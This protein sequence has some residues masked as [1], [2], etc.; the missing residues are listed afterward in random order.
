MLN[1]HF[2]TYDV[3]AIVMCVC[4]CVCVCACGSGGWYFNHVAQ[5]RTPYLVSLD[6]VTGES[7]SGRPHRP[8][9]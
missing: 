5:V 9:L 4:V 3:V 1:L 7:G 2:V 8:I 6:V